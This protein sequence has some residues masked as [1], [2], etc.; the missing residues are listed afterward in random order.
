MWIIGSNIYFR[1]LIAILKQSGHAYWGTTIKKTCW[2]LYLL[3][4]VE[5]SAEYIKN[6]NE[7]VIG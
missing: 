5:T 2:A 6:I 7:G 4:G 1:G 3:G